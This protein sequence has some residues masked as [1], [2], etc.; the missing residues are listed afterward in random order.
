VCGIAGFFDPGNE[1]G[2][3]SMH[4]HAIDMTNSLVHRGPDDGG[5]WVDPTAGVALGNRRLAIIDLSRTTVRSTTTRRSL[6]RSSRP[7]WRHAGEVTRT[8]R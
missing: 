2:P 3:E 6:A 8:P 7:V 4:R 5:T 1:R